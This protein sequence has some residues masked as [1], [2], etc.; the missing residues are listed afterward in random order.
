MSDLIDKAK[1]KIEAISLEVVTMEEKDIPVMGKI[2][3]LLCDME[4]V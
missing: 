2:L 3:N 4:T 1:E